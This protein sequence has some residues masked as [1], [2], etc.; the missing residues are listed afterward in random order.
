MKSSFSARTNVYRI[1]LDAWFVALYVV[2]GTFASIKIPGVI[3][4][5]FSTLPILLAAFLFRPLDAVGIALLG[6]FVEQV[7]DPSPYGFVTMPMWLIPGTVVALVA[8]F[9][10]MYARSRGSVRTRLILTVVTIVVSELLLTLLNTAALY[11]DGAI[12]GYSVKALHLLLPARLLNGVGRA[13]ISSIA[14]P[15]LYTP[16][17]K[18]LTKLFPR[19]S[20]TND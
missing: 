3:Q 12:L 19:S 17:H 9:G 16:L 13:V 8:S 15:L 11:I 1:T 14:V 2:L 20:S 18:V 10:A 6:T 5:S 7:I 4:I